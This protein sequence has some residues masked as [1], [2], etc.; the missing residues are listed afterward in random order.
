MKRLLSTLRPQ[1]FHHWLTI[2]AFQGNNTPP[3]DFANLYSELKCND[4]CRTLKVLPGQE[5]PV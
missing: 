2:T 1:P 4:T 5:H 3:V